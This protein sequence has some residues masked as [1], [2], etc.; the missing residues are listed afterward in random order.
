MV[1]TGEQNYQALEP[2]SYSSWSDPELSIGLIYAKKK[3]TRKREVFTGQGGPEKKPFVKIKFK[4]IK[5]ISGDYVVPEKTWFPK[6]DERD[7]RYELRR[8]ESPKNFVFWD[9][10]G[11][12]VPQ[13]SGYSG[14]TSCGPMS[15][16]TLLPGQHYLHFK[17]GERTIG[18]E[19]V[20]GPDDPLVLDFLQIAEGVP[21]T[22]IRRA[23]KDYFKDI[24]GYQDFVLEVCPTE[25]ELEA[26]RWGYSLDPTVPDTINTALSQSQKSTHNSDHKNLKALDF[27][28]YQKRVNGQ[29][30][31]CQAGKRYLVL[32]KRS[33]DLSRRR[34]AMF[35]VAPPQ[36][37]YIEITDGMI[38]TR[39]VLSHITILPKEDG[40]TLLDVAQVKGWIEEANAQ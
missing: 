36:H 25:S 21:E 22:K 33:P 3:K 37:R 23:P 16:D 8:I 14:G 5:N 40:S 29:D 24:A 27:M 38:D 12:S 30:W 6:I 13:V 26:L 28:S 31:T 7:E 20:S 32:D 34:V 15:S 1:R 2:S 11:L 18:F 10:R 9:R 39:E 17:K 35:F 4:L 19:I